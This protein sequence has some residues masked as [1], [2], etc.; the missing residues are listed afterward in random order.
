MR[1]VAMA[2]RTWLDEAVAGWQRFWFTPADPATLA[3]IRICAGL[4]LFYTHAVWTLGL[5]DFFGA[6]GWVSPEAAYAFQAP[7]SDGGSLPNDPYEGRSFAWSWFYWIDDSAVRM[8]VHVAG[9][10]VFALLALGCFTRVVS[11]LSYLV[12]LAYVHRT[13][14]ALFGLDQI[15]AMLAMYLIVGPAGARYSIDAWW[16]RRR[17]DGASVAVE[18]SIAA[19]VAIRLI[20]LHMCII[21]LFAGIGKLTGLSWWLG[22]GVWGG[23]ANYEYQSIDVTWMADWPLLGAFLSHLTVYWEVFYIAAIWPRWTRPLMLLIAIPLHLGIALFMGM[24]TFG[25][26][27]LIGNLAFVPPTL[28]RSVIERGRPATLPGSPDRRAHAVA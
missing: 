5:E 9:L 26:V 1:A 28:V 8:A 23:L 13:P 17:T 6:H 4:M 10:V 20:Q 15:N 22:Y 16:R 21:Y 24:I 27:M 25:L 18:K 3:L 11:V 7:P 2:V 19:N 14:G 12:V